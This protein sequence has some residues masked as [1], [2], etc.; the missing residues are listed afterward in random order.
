[1]DQTGKKVANQ[2]CSWSAEQRKLIFP[3]PCWRLRIWFRETGSAV[4]SRVSLLILH[5]QAKYGA[6][7]RDSSRFPRWFPLSYTNN[8]YQV[9]PEFIRSRKCV[10]TAFTA[11]SPV[12]WSSRDTSC[13]RIRCV[14][15]H[16]YSVLRPAAYRV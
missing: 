3:R 1:M 6:N 4:P 14:F 16:H 8:H 7:V 12:L 13:L 5:N 10:L 9:S 15:I 2:S 11:E